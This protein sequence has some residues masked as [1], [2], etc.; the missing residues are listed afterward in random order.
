MKPE[1]RM[2]DALG[3]PLRYGDYIC[4]ATTLRPGW[5]KHAVLQPGV[6]RSV[7]MGKNG[8]YCLVSKVDLDHKGYVTHVGRSL[9][10][11]ESRKIVRVPAP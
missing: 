10:I 5:G 9:P 8:I 7:K 6:V 1:I 11:R 4:Y 3:R 2:V